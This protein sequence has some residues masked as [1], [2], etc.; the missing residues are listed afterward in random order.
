[1][2]FQ[3]EEIMKNNENESSKEAPPVSLIGGL[4]SFGEFDSF[5][6]NFWL[7]KWHRLLEWG[8]PAGIEKD[9]PNVDIIDHDN[10][11]EVLAALPGIK[12]E[13]M[14]VA[15]NNHGITICTFGKVQEKPEGK[16]FSR[17]K[18]KSDYQQRTL[19]LPDHV[20]YN[21][22]K[23]SF[24]DDMLIVTIPKTEKSQRKNIE[25]K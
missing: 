1:M 10:E 22:A 8:F 25:I 17:A 2:L 4:L 7:R 9:F 18:P 19:S 16:Y 3:G 6:D 12:R 21:N 15:I 24:K 11:I 20:D 13:N 23:A 5:F 14:D